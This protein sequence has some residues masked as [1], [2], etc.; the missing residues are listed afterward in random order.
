M[1]AAREAMAKVVAARG[2]D[3]LEPA[4]SQRLESEEQWL[5]ERIGELTR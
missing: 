5:V 3:D 1:S 2:R 4:L